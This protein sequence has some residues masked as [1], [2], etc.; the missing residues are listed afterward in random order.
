MATPTA[1]AIPR[2]SLAE[3]L[4]IADP[5]YSDNFELYFPE[6]PQI[7]TGKTGNDGGLRLQCKTATVPGISNEA[8]DVTLHGFKLQTAGRTVFQNTLSVTYLE[9]RTLSIQRVLKNW[10]NSVRDFRTQKSVG[11]L[12][13]VAHGQLHLYN[14][15][16]EIAG[17]IFLYNCFCAEVQDISMD[18]NSANV[19]E[20]SATF[21]YDFADES[22]D[23]AGQSPTLKVQGINSLK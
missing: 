16:G 6:L 22:G 8:Q 4:A 18:G 20:V 10:V 13:Y 23:P 19:T 2:S 15:V 1:S 11:K 9:T 7:G 3:V 21:R 12:N 5:L 14:E 17:T